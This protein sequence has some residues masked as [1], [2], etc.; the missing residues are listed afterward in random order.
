MTSFKRLITA[1]I[2]LC[3]G[4]NSFAQDICRYWSGTLQVSGQSL[5]IG[6]DISADASGALKASMDVKEQSAFGIPANEISF[7]AGILKIGIA[8]L[9]AEYR[10]MFVMNAFNGTFTQMGV[11]IPLVLAPAEKPHMDRPQEPRPP[12]PYKAE[13]VVFTN[14]RENFELAGTLTL[15]EGDGPFPGVVLVSGSGQQ[16]R[17]EELMG[18]KTFAVIADWLTRRGIAVLRYDD[19]GVGGSGGDPAKATTMDNSYD[20][21][22][23]TD[24]LMKRPEI[25]FVGVMGHSEGGEIAYMLGA[26]R[27]VDIAF[28][29]SLAGPAVKGSDCLFEQ[30]KAIYKANG[31]PEPS[32][33]VMPK[34][35]PW[36]QYF[37]DYDPEADIA[38]IKCPLLFVNGTKDLQV[39]SYQNVPA[40]K[41]IIEKYGLK[42]VEIREMDGLNHLF[43]HATTGS[44]TEYVTISETISEEVLEIV[45]EWIA[46]QTSIKR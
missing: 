41:A 44:P 13:E 25:S 34:P 43:Q 46:G 20:A 30:Q 7:E 19:R 5:T 36:M 18:H 6:F 37:L 28:L 14:T 9:G 16:N 35:S 31:L 39:L 4:I 1:A 15:P 10:A 17:D 8:S 11:Q 23:A 24:Y 26:R 42:N 32:S 40:L 27:P 33:L 22:A 45:C 2:L 12:F 29:V 3:L 38:G 21:E